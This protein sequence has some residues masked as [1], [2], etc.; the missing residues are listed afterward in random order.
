MGGCCRVQPAP[1]DDNGIK[2]YHHATQFFPTGW[3]PLASINRWKIKKGPTPDFLIYVPL[4]EVTDNYQGVVI[5]NCIGTSQDLS[6][7]PIVYFQDAISFQGKDTISGSYLLHISDKTEHPLNKAPPGCLNYVK[8]TNSYALSQ[9]QLPQQFYYAIKGD[10][11]TPQSCIKATPFVRY[12]LEQ[13]KP[14][15]FRYLCN[16][17]QMQ[18]MPKS[19]LVYGYYDLPPLSIKDLDIGIGA[20]D[21]KFNVIGYVN[22]QK[23]SVFNN[24]LHWNF[25]NQ[26]KHWDFSLGTIISRIDL[27]SLPNEV[28]FL[29]I[30]VSVAESGYFDFSRGG[31]LQIH[32]EEAK[33]ELFRIEARQKGSGSAV[34]YCVLMRLDDGNWAALPM[35]KGYK[36]PGSQPM[37]ASISAVARDLQDQNFLNQQLKG[38]E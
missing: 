30:Y 27:S 37:Y 17:F 36:V 20:I 19:L 16:F 4:I 34:N 2:V 25:R 24:A 21:S 38:L 5:L 15:T 22:H 10:I 32:C 7:E 23:P 1:L 31:F 29:N 12:Y 9:F 13:G 3:T 14:R 35:V 28:K 6:L 26:T 18:Q 8:L 33:R 11:V